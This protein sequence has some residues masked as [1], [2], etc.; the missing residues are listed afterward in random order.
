[1]AER[2]EEF[3]YPL[4]VLWVIKTILETLHTAI[5]GA[6]NDLV[7]HGLAKQLQWRPAQR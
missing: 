6:R 7:L 4:K 3:T 5:E 1:M 2:Y